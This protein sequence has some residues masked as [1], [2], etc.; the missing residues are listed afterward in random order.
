MVGDGYA[1]LS[2]L[3]ALALA[4]S[5]VRKAST[6]HSKQHSQ[7]HGTDEV[8]DLAFSVR[9]CDFKYVLPPNIVAFFNL[10]IRI[11][12]GYRLVAANGNSDGQSDTLVT[13]SSTTMGINT[14][15]SVLL[16]HRGPTVLVHQWI[17]GQLLDHRVR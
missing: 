11:D 10:D 12:G 6:N 13:I 5:H 14:K 2:A 16:H 15:P 3:P 9:R 4:Y 1:T 7:L 8:T 17:L